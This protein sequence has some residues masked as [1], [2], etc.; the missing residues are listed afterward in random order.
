M[1]ILCIGNSFSQDTTRLLSKVALSAS[2]ESVKIAN[3]YIGG[4][5]V[6]RHWLNARKDIPGY[7]Y[8]VDKGN[9]VLITPNYRISEALLDGPWDWVSI[10]HGSGDGSFYSRPED[11]E[12]FPQL[13]EYIRRWVPATTRLAFHMS[14]TAEP[15]YQHH[16]VRYYG[17]DQ[18]L[19]YS[20]LAATTKQVMEPM[21]GLDR[22]CPT[23]TAIQNA[24][25]ADLG[26]LTRDNF[27]LSFGLGRY[28]AAV[29]FYI[30][31]T[32]K[33]ADSVR[34]CPDSVDAHQMAVAHR[35]AEAAIKCPYE[36]TNL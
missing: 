16:E 27:H 21:P 24:R 32:G 26:L 25:T 3:L 17:R 5:S 15:E 29:T 34:W 30:A 33:T 4:C 23:G 6:R 1:R 18:L 12:A 22:V 8:E 13:L 19:F 35:A 9:G 11:Y 31:L 7:R 2:E 20:K 14:W 10:Q 28:I 36:I